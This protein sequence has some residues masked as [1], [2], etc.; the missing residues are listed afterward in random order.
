[1]ERLEQKTHLEINTD[2]ARELAMFDEMFGVD[3]EGSAGKLREI[4]I[5]DYFNKVAKKYEQRREIPDSIVRLDQEGKIAEDLRDGNPVLIRGN[6]RIGKTS[7]AE[8]LKTH[9]FGDKNSLLIDA[10]T[11]VT[12]P[13]ESLDVFKKNFAISK[14]SEFISQLESGDAFNSQKIE[15]QIKKSNKTPFEFLNDYFSQ[16]G[17]KVFLSIDEIVWFAQEPEKLKYLADLKDLSH[18]QVAPVL[19]RIALREDLF[20]ETFNGY[21]THFIRALTVEEVGILIRGPLKGTAITFTDDAVQKIFEFT[22]GRPLEVNNICYAVM[23]AKS[24]FKDHKFTYRAKD[25]EKL[26]GGRTNNL[27]GQISPFGDAIY[28]YEAVYEWSMSDEERII[29]KKLA[30]ENEISI[31]E[32]NADKIQPLIDTTFVVKDDS[33]GVYRINGQLFKRV[34][35]EI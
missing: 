29:I 34:I 14:I 15:E 20:K 11:Y 16:K 5:N 35:L 8:S 1:M 31:S 24:I 6:W 25:I 4:K 33:K 17:E 23:G 18:M 30:K 32:I 10:R 27:K 19:H 28:N 9:Q 12:R 2:E 21:K 7:M 3:K 13:E 22:G 26:T